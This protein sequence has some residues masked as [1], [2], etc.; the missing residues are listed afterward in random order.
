MN[1][2][3]IHLTR[4]L[5][6]LLLTPTLWGCTQSEPNPLGPEAVGLRG[7]YFDNQNFTGKQV[8]RT[9]GSINFNWGEG[10]PITGIVA[11]TFSVRWTGSIAPRYSQLYTFIVNADD[12]VRLWVNGVKLIEDWDYTPYTRYGKLRLEANKRYAIKLEYNEGVV[13]ASIRLEWQSASQQREVISSQLSTASGLSTGLSENARLRDLAHARGIAIGGALLPQPLANE[14]KYRD[15]AKREFNFLSPENNFMITT[16]Q[17]GSDPF[18][19]I[20]HLTDLDNQINFARENASQVQAFHLV[21]YLESVWA[22]WLNDLPENERWFLIQKRIRDLM[23]RYRGKVKTY[24]VVNEAFDEE[25]R[26]RKGPFYFDGELKENWLSPLG[27][28]YIEY[29]FKEA[30]KADP[31]AKLYYNDYGLESDGPKWDVVLNMV[32]DFK[33]RNVPIDGVGFQFHLSLNYGLPDPLVVTNHFR[34]LHELGLQVRMT[35]FDLGIEG[36]AG[37]ESQR[38]AQQ[39][40]AY[41]TYLNVCLAAPNCTAFHMWGFTDKHSWLTEPGWGGSP[42]NKPLIFDTNYQPKPSYYGLKDALLGR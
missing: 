18:N 15:T 20:P 36:A 26:V 28:G 24:N 3:K 32:K 29:A 27:Y 25:G 31:T 39:A 38:L 11:D 16:T 9:D 37:T 12:G 5:L 4:V 40:R 13:G 30:R 23:I 42:A 22:T 34:E 8:T 6:Y 14:A 19:L 17:S 35:E 33:T 41:K 21:W 10:S 7:V 1:E 2:K